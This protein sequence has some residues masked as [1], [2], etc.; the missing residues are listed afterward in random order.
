MDN[1]L[2]MMK[3]RKG[4]MMKN[5]RGKLMIGICVLMC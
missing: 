2:I 1:R 5:W 4:I 3:M